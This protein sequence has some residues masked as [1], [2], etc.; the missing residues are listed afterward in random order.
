MYQ[1]SSQTQSQTVIN[2]IGKN[3][4]RITTSTRQTK[5]NFI[6]IQNLTSKEQE[7]TSV[8]STILIDKS[9]A[10]ARVLF[11]RKQ[12]GANRWHNKKVSR[13]RWVGLLSTDSDLLHFSSP[14]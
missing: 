13:P 7:S 3:I 4:C 8:T 11:T 1:G 6:R 5:N 10:K 14:H 12:K 2:P 9:Q